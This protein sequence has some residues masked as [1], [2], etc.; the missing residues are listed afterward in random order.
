MYFRLKRNWRLVYRPFVDHSR[1]LVNKQCSFNVSMFN[2]KRF[3]K[4]WWRTKT[5]QWWHQTPFPW[6]SFHTFHDAM[7]RFP[8]VLILSF[9]HASIAYSIDYTYSIYTGNAVLDFF[10]FSLTWITAHDPGAKNSTKKQLNSW[11]TDSLSESFFPSYFI[12]SSQ[13]ESSLYDT[14]LI[15]S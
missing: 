14:L 15:C 11:M 5:C 8:E 6:E 4:C 10:L 1:L 7:A 9:I 13:D 3:R 12:S 2:A